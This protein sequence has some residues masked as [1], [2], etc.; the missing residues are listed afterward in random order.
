VGVVPTG[1]YAYD[2]S[3]YH[4]GPLGMFPGGYAD[5]GAGFAGGLSDFLK[6]FFNMRRANTIDADKY[7]HCM[8]NCQAARRGPAGVAFSK[9]FSEAREISDHYIKGDTVEDC[10]ADRR[11]NDQ[12]RR[13]G[14]N[15]PNTP[16]E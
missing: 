12:G 2:P 16:C 9:A 8:A 4:F 7:F 5:T 1:N 10:N 13:G 3:G 15:D 6:N 14:Q 11:A